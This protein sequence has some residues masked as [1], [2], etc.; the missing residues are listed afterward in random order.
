MAVCQV[1]AKMA[2]HSAWES[3]RVFLNRM[4]LGWSSIPLSAALS[5][6][7]V[8]DVIEAVRRIALAHAAF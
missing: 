5:D 7:D 3:W 4:G 6:A 1:L 2:S 8:S